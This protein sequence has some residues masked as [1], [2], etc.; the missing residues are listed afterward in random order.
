MAVVTTTALVQTVHTAQLLQHTAIA[1]DTYEL[2]CTVVHAK[3]STSKRC[4]FWDRIVPLP[5]KGI[6]T[7]VNG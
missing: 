6:T 5:Q 3:C 1:V 2:C 7:M 4:R